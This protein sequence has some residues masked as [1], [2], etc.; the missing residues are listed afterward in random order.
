VCPPLPAAVS[1]TT[2][3]HE[4]ARAPTQV[5]NDDFDINVYKRSLEGKEA[6]SGRTADYRWTEGGTEVT[7]WVPLPTGV[8][9]KDVRCKFTTRELD[10]QIGDDEAGDGGGDGGGGAE[11]G[12][13]APATR[14]GGKLKGPVMIDDCYWVIDEDAEFGRAVQVVLAKKGEFTRWAGALVG[15]VETR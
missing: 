1:P 13:A 2:A 3:P 5:E 9:S 10:F 14:F 11:G 15:E 7:L 12:A 6:A 8:R 4:C